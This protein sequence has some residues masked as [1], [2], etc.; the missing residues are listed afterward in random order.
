MIQRPYL[1]QKDVLGNN[2]GYFDDPYE[3]IK[4]AAGII[5]LTNWQ[6]YKA[7][8]WKLAEALT[9]DRALLINI[10]RVLRDIRLDGFKYGC[11]SFRTILVLIK[12]TCYL[13][14]SSKKSKITIP[15]QTPKG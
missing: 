9:K 6:E 13:N 10:W 8:D 3:Y 14:V 15:M 1:R 12:S 2:A 7:L 5:L 4:N 11:G